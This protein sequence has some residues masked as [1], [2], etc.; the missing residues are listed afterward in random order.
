M[1]NA[2]KAL[3]SILHPQIRHTKPFNTANK[4]DILTYPTWR[5]RSLN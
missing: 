5:R 3:R 1:V 4:A 2:S